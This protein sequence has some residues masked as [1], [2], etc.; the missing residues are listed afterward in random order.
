M[1]RRCNWATRE[2]SG[3][4]ATV[5]SHWLSENAMQLDDGLRALEPLGLTPR[6]TRFVMTVAL[7]GGYCLRRHYLQFAGL[8]YGK[9]VRDFLDKLV[10]RCLAERFRYQPNRG[11]VY[12]LHAKSLYRRLNQEDNRNRRR[13]SPPLIARKLMLLDYVL[14]VPSHDWY[15]T[16][17]DKVAFFT[18]ELNVPLSDLPQRAFRA[19]VSH[20]GTIRYF[21]H[22]LPIYVTPEPRVVQFVYLATDTT[23]RAFGQFLDDH[24]RLLA[25]LP[26]W[27]VAVGSHR[28]AGLL[29]CRT[30]FDRFMAKV[31]RPVSGQDVADLQWFFVASQKVDRRD[32]RDLRVADL[33]R[34]RD[35]RERF[36]GAEFRALYS[37]W[38]S[39]GDAVFQRPNVFAHVT[40][41]Q[42]ITHLLPSSYTRFGLLPGVA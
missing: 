29:M 11:Y 19:P 6:Q 10:D 40:C 22:K 5:E 17:E 14:S 1:A 39:A 30:V 42:L 15:A 35:L 24:V 4:T 31:S 38:C 3:K 41:G 28:P 20:D 27:A 23:G 25:H 34:F 12:H 9:N 2:L 26:A 33:D 8:R 32:M 36:A 37:A 7:H 21:I 13:V 16:E 18:R